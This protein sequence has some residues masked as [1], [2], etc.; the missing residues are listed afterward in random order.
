MPKLTC[1][2]PFR[3]PLATVSLQQNNPFSKLRSLAFAR[4]HPFRTDS[5]PHR[6]YP[7]S[8]QFPVR[9][10]TWWWPTT[11]AK[12]TNRAEIWIVSGVQR[13][14]NLWGTFGSFRTSEKNKTV[15]LTGSSRFCKPRFSSPQ[16]WLRTNKIK[17]FQKGASRFCK[18]RISA[19]NYNFAQCQLNPFAA[20][21]PFR[22]LW[23]H[24]S[25]G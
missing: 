25:G 12:I 7:G 15:S 19:Q 14:A 21:R 18:P 5:N 10:V 1:N 2:C 9:P 24:P 4:R 22:R 16:W 20:P 11:S 3:I 17:T 8:L 6:R 13:F 23:R